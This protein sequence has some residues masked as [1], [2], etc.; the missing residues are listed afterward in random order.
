MTKK[1]SRLRSIC[2]DF[3]FLSP[4][5]Q[6]VIPTSSCERIPF[7]TDAQTTDTILMPSEGPEGIANFD[8]VPNLNGVIVVTSEEE[9][10]RSRERDRGDSTRDIFARIRVEFIVGSKIEES[11]RGI[12]RTGDEGL[13]VGKERDGVDVG[14]MSSESV[15]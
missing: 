3:A 11:A 6:E 8:G 14:F 12:I 4:N 5:L 9:A 2:L 10:P 7:R 1:S 15:G 13:T